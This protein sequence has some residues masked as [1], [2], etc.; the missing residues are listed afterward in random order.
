M[1]SGGVGPDGGGG[2][3]AGGFREVSLG[4]GATDGVGPLM[5]MEPLPTVDNLVFGGGG[6]SE[7]GTGL[8]GG[9]ISI[10]LSSIIFWS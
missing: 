6:P 4:F 10:P 7:A 8:T 2:V 9:V 5:E 1:V 3:K